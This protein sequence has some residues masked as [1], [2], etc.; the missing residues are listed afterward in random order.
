MAKQKNDL[1]SSGQLLKAFDNSLNGIVIGVGK[2]P[3]IIYANSAFEKISGYR[4]NE[5][6]SFSRWQILKMVHR[7][8]QKMFF[9]NYIKRLA[10]EKI[11][12]HYQFRGIKKDGTV[13]WFEEIGR[14]HV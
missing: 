2:F 11:P 10:G 5:L 9:G 12:N 8:D 7:E 14:A 3:K 6:K 1:R 4:K 13:R